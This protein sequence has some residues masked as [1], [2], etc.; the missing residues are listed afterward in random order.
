MM[1]TSK[2]HAFFRMF[3]LILPYKGRLALFVFSI[4][5]YSAVVAGIVYLIKYF[6]GDAVKSKDFALVMRVAGL[7]L[8]C[9]FLRAYFLFRREVTARYLENRAVRD[10]VDKVVAHV[11]RMDLGFF[12]RW[13]SGELVSR[14]MTDATAVSFALRIATVIFQEPLTIAALVAV[15]VHLDP[16][17]ALVG[18]VG[19][20]VAVVPLYHIYKRLFRSSRRMR[21]SAAD[22]ADS[23]VQVFSGLRVVKAYGQEETEVSDFGREN[24]E[25][26]RH[27]MKMMRARAISKPVVEAI[28]GAGLVAAFLLG[29]YFFINDRVN[30]GTLFALMMALIQ[31]HRPVRAMAYAFSE[32]AGAL[33]GAMRAF[34]L[35]DEENMVKDSPGA[36]ELKGVKRG[37]SLRGVRFDYGRE[38][39]LEGVD[40][41]IRAGET[42][43]VVG[44][45]GVGKSTIINLICRF[46]DPKEGRVE[47]DGIDLRGIRHA[48]LLSQ[49]ALVTQEP[50]LFNTSVRENILY[51]RPGASDAEVEAAARAAHIHD[52]IVSFPDCYETMCGE[53]GAKMSVG[54]KQR[55]ALARAIL[56]DAPVLLLDEPTSSL[57]TNSERLIQEAVDSFRAGRITVLVAH[58]LSTV[59]GADR[60]AVLKDGRVEAVGAHS[61]LIEKSPTYA[62]LWEAQRAAEAAAGAGA[63][64]AR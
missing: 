6:V 53:R 16:F 45:T 20:P 8:G 25:R 33:P 22:M 12:D 44:P 49:V 27:Q 32:I 50:F 24:S 56:R 35:L 11:V 51:G 39:V 2:L 5:G 63:G 60:I 13:R 61:E 28:N 23:M 38:P 55:I 37:I 54:Q 59:A 9:W 14:V 26:F 31:L 48:S 46:Y 58:R 41:E 10:I 15:T 21:E 52:E 30:V 17:L 36:V 42:L 40:L 7:L 3:K 4:L 47:I 62:R 64:S 34:E 1:R 18:F 43:A 19:F 57:D 29:A